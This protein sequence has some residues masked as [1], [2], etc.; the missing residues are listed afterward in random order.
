M[1]DPNSNN[2]GAPQISAP[3]A[4]SLAEILSQPRTW[5]E[6]LKALDDSTVIRDITKRFAKSPEWLFVGCGSSYYI[7]LAAAASWSAITGTRAR[8]LPAS[9]LLLFPDLQL[10]GAADFVPVLISRSG[11]TSEVLRVAQFFNQKKIPTI[12]ISC[13]SKQRLQELA[14][15]S[16]LLPGVDEQSTVMTRSFTS[17]LLALQY[18]AATLAG[19]A[20]FTE[21]LRKL[22]VAAEKVLHNL[23]MRVR[24]FASQNQFADYVCL[25]QGPYY[26]LAC[27]SGLKLTEMSCSYTQSFHTL[28]FRHG[29]KSM[30]SRETLIMFLLSQSN[31][32]AET[33]VLEEIKD[34]GATTLVVA[35]RID[36]RARAAADFVVELDSGLPEFSCIAPFVFAGQ[37]MGLYTALQ[38]GLDPDR[39]RNLSRVVIL[40]DEKKPSENAS[41]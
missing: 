30:V 29:P 26:G 8:A 12:A 15:M 2:G 21:S 10:A 25:G 1:S 27:E 33:D 13:A 6:C 24:E 16:I 38:K 18:L 40:K 37:L 36:D 4:Y 39:P 35:D 22:P 9:E 28:E 34:L 5:S 32:A 31:Y 11:H 7:A 14:S 19:K 23:P 20:N 17:M 41:I 3:G